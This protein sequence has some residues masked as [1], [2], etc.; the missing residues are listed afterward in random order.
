VSLFRTAS[1][2]GD[3]AIN[4]PFW[5]QT[6]PEKVFRRVGR[7]MQ[8]AEAELGLATMPKIRSGD[9]E[10]T[11][12]S[13][14]AHG[15]AFAKET[16]LKDSLSKPV[17]GPAEHFCSGMSLS[18]PDISKLPAGPVSEKSGNPQ[19]FLRMGLVEFLPKSGRNSH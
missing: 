7:K 17:K 3:L 4:P 18:G 19:T 15:N 6:H 12:L 1:V 5:Q 9:P 13:L 2:G 10:T 11:A 14:L 16:S 8:D